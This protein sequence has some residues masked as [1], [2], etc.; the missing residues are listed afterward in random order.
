MTTEA[1]E[2]VD[3]TKWAGAHFASHLDVGPDLGM[4]N[5]AIEESRLLLL[6]RSVAHFRHVPGVLGVLLQGSL[7]A[8]T[9]DEFSDI[10]LRVVA[11]AET[12]GRLLEDRIDAPTKWGDFLFNESGKNHCI[13][14]FRPFVKLEVYY[15]RAEE[16][17]PSPW[18]RSPVEIPFDPQGL[19]A[20]VVLRSQTL[21]HEV[22]PASLD[23]VISKGLDCACEVFR[24]TRRGQVIHAQ[25]LLPMLRKCII[26]ADD[27]IAGRP[28]DLQRFRHEE[29]LDSIVRDLIEDSF[30]GSDPR[31]LEASML[32][33]LKYFREQVVRL[34]E[35]FPVPRSLQNDLFVFDFLLQE[36]RSG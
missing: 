26:Q 18:Y 1:N 10:D 8:G 3:S 14:H 23:F 16:M 28:P 29:R 5:Q 7:P 2:S 33:L 30:V 13:S 24:R 17:K 31:V 11:E 20:D 6:E 34:Y 22:E 36:G 25:E 9:A 4:N 27:W 15:F 12:Y 35:M 21:A 32:T 19:I